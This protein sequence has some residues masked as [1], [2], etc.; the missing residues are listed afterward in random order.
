MRLTVTSILALWLLLCLPRIAVPADSVFRANVLE[1]LSADV[2]LLKKRNAE[3]VTVKLFGIDCPKTGQSY[4]I[5]AR[6][7]A[8]QRVLG[9]EV[10]VRPETGS[11]E[12]EQPMPVTILYN[13]DGSQ[14]SLNSELLEAGMARRSIPLSPTDLNLGELEAEARKLRR[15]L[16]ADPGAMPAFGSLPVK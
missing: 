15:G 14:R 12:G 3:I 7:F 9:K 16:W 10:T 1:I 11:Y 8:S 13:E 6:L 2:I 5:K 4:F